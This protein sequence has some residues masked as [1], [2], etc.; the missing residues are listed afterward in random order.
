MGY[1]IGD[2][3]LCEGIPKALDIVVCGVLGAKGLRDK[4]DR[5]N[6]DRDDVQRDTRHPAV[7][8]SSTKIKAYLP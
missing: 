1:N 3:K 7:R 4:A 8:Y 6:P 5:L 2:E